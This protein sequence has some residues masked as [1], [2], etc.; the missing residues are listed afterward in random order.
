MKKLTFFLFCI[1]SLFICNAQTGYTIKAKIDNPNNYKMAVSYF[2]NNKLVRDTNCTIEDGWSVFRGKVDEPVIA[3]LNVVRNPALSIR[4]GRSF[5]PG[6]PFQF[7]L[8]NEE[9]TITGDANTVYMAETTG[10]KANKE[11]AAIKSKQSKLAHESWMAQKSAFENFKPGDDS[12]VFVNANKLRF[13]N[14]EKDKKLQKDF[15]HKNQNS[16]VSMYFLACIVDDLKQDDLKAEYEK[17]G[18]AYKNTSVAKAIAGKIE[19]M[20]AT[21]IGKLAVAINKKDINGNDINLQTLKGKYVLIDFWG[22]WC[23]PCRA[24]HPHL[25]ELYTKYKNDGFE[26]L[27]IAQELRQHVE[28]ARKPWKDAIEQDG[29]PWLQVLN[30]EGIDKFDAVKAYGVTAFPTK[31]LLDRSGVIIAR[32]VGDNEDFDKKLK[33]VFGK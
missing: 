7:V 27:G 1:C 33:E 10:G 8:T 13:E 31:I 23:S 29:L 16:F 12:A 18:D 3:G 20:E 32:Y 11:W 17:L 30:D 4:V 24:S 5:I 21:N 25:K 28:E 22:S 14:E 2:V 26:I 15:I 19:G 9:I 6:P